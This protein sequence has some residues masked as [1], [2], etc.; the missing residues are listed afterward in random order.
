[1]KLMITGSPGTG[2]TTLAKK[3]AKELN[4]EYYNEKDFAL[5]HGLGEFNE[6]NELEI[7]LKEFEKE[8]NKEL[9]EKENIVFEGHV[10][11]ECKLDIDL[12]LLITVDP[13]TLELRLE[14]R[15]YSMEK[16]MNNV[17]CEGINY[18]KKQLKRLYNTK[19][20]IEI[21]SLASEEETFLFA[22]QKIQE[23]MN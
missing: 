7:P 4:L 2:K 13:E 8:A 17:F 16:V 22:I 9:K 23:Y 3:I 21:N 19:K 1:M 10:I 15:N 20:I 5:K 12:I 14:Q 18:C 11:C 6:E